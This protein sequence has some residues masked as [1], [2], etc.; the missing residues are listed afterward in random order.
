[1]TCRD[2]PA[3]RIEASGLRAELIVSEMMKYGLSSRKTEQWRK[4]LSQS[5]RAAPSRAAVAQPVRLVA[6]ETS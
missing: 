4:V 6:K 2:G 5:K 3:F 1:M